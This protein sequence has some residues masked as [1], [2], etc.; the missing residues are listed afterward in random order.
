M[1]IGLMLILLYK[2]RHYYVHN[3]FKVAGFIP[4]RSV[5]RILTLPVNY[6]C[7][8]KQGSILQTWMFPP[9]QAFFWNGLHLYPKIGR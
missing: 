9:R 8:G 6:L 2:D 5:T 7:K 3:N 4:D 1:F